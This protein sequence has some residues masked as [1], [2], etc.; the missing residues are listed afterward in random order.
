MA[1]TH[2]PKPD[3]QGESA[4]EQDPVAA[5][6]RRSSRYTTYFL[7]IL[8]LVNAANL[9]DRLVL[10]VLLQDIKM[11]LGLSDTQLGLLT[12]LAFAI[13][14]AG[15]G[16]PLARWADRGNRVTILAATT[17]IFSGAVALSAL[18]TNFIQLL[19]ARVCAGAGESGCQPS[20]L[21]LI[22]DHFDRDERPRAVARFALG[23][24]IAL[25]CGYYI[26][27]WLNEWVGWRATLAI[28]A[29]PGILLAMITALTLREPR[30]LLMNGVDRAASTRSGSPPSRLSDVLITLLRSGTY[31][32]LLVAYALQSFFVVG[33]VQW[34]PAFFARSFDMSSGSLGTWLAFCYGMTGFVGI[35]LGGELATRFAGGN[36]RRQILGVLGI[37]LGL[38]ILKTV[39]YLLPTYELIFSML[40]FISILTGITN[41]PLFATI[42]TIVPSHMRATATAILFFS[43][44]L[45][46]A[47]LGPLAVGVLSDALTPTLGSEALRYALVVM[48]PGYLWSAM[49]LWLAS[50][51]MKTENYAEHQQQAA[52]A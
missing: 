13:F 30:Q 8:M 36:E 42:Q 11:E 50:R 12:G 24:P 47:G 48:G 21:S 32:H 33:V 4:Q 40:A 34:Q 14:Y 27:G 6:R 15:V 5:V 1:E 29:V 31:R 28:M 7:C 2:N 35:W 37:F 45:I 25:F 38:A 51:H 49:H 26:A 20:A 17:A 10:S 23:G 9:M 52:G 19:V 46:G 41:G 3:R 16:I 44:N 39:I 18:V 22:S 43:A